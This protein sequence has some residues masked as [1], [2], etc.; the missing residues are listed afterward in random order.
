MDFVLTLHSHL[1]Y[2]LNHGR[3][4]HGS[5]WITEAAID[6]Y[7]PLVE[8]LRALDADGVKAPVTI[9]FTPVLANQLASDTFRRELDVYFEQ[10]LQHCDEAP[11]SLRSTGDASLIPLVEYWRERLTRLRVLFRAI[12]GDIIA[13]FRD[14]EARGRLEIIG[15]AATHGFLPLLSRDE[16]IQLQLD[17]GVREH[18]RLFGRAPRGAW[19]PECAYRP[20]GPWKPLPNAPNTGVRPGIEEYLANAGF[21]YFFVDAHMARAGSPLGLYGQVVANELEHVA[22]PDATWEP[23]RTPYRAYRVTSAY[24]PQTVAA[25]IRDPES[26]AQVWSRFQGYPGDGRYLEFHKIRWPGGLKLWRVTGND[27]DLGAKEPYDPVTASAMTSAHGAHFAS[28][29]A[30]IATQH[31][32]HRRG[33]VVAPFDTELF[34][35]WWYEGPEFLAN[36]YR[37]LQAQ[38][39]VKPATASDH[40]AVQTT[41]TGLRLAPGSWGANGDYSMWLNSQ[42]AWTWPKIWGLE[43]RFWTTAREAIELPA[44]HDALAQAARELL[45]VQSSDW[46]FIISTGAVTD[47]A[48]RRFNGHVDACDRL[49]D[50][51][52]DGLASG[53]LT[54]ATDAASELRKQDDLFPEILGSLRTVL[55][56]I[57]NRESGIDRRER[58]R[59]IPIPD[60][61]FPIPDR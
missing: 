29:L 30:T 9:G 28:L 52:R 20:R 18:K 33:V 48:I 8:A 46:Q 38:P 59:R 4:P 43:E 36:V 41:R 25:F 19:V 24:M 35:H 27:V 3:W 14:F 31:P 44:A 54:S 56:G 21:R 60:S 15:S 6:T 1:P 37:A 58:P 13:A 45:L 39:V 42:T 7:L 34:G 40:L 55:S 12:D 17:V 32:V 49:L 23:T 47:Y 16:S 61:L 10:R 57:G 2:V 5:D 50:A 22:S 53:D 51:I 11:A 26:S